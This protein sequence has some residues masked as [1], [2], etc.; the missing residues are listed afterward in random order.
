MINIFL[1][2]TIEN[3]IN[4]VDNVENI[5]G[6]F[7]TNLDSDE[8]VNFYDSFSI[9]Y[10]TLDINVKKLTDNPNIISDPWMLFDTYNRNIEK[11]IPNYTS[12]PEKKFICMIW[13]TQKDFRRKIYDFVNR[14]SF[15]CF[16]SSV[17]NN[18]ELT[19]MPEHYPNGYYKDKERNYGVPKEYFKSFIDVVSESYVEFSTHF[20]EKTYKPLLLK[21]VFLTYAGPYYYETLSEFGFEL[22]DELFDYSFD[23][24]EDKN[25]RL[26]LFFQQLEK[27]NEMTFDEVKYI[28]ESINPKIV[29]NHERLKLVKSKFNELK[30]KANRFNV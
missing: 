1:K 7:T 18:V 17:D 10:W 11:F 12:V 19:E 29:R 3:E 22:Y 30:T 24:V 21:K 23:K 2:K 16:C 27:V 25:E 20:S 26:K 28:I 8:I 13:K 5:A 6:H 9:K 15:D 14:E 4:L